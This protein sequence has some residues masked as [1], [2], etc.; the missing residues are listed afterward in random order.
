[1][2]YTTPDE[3]YEKLLNKSNYLIFTWIPY[4]VVEKYI[5]KNIEDY[6]IINQPDGY[7]ATIVKFVSR[8][9]RK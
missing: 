2:G 5:N 3:I 7:S 9:K 6:T 4:K 8:D 1:M